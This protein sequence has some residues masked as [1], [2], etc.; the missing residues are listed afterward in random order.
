MDH[1]TDIKDQTL[2]QALKGFVL[3]LFSWLAMKYDVPPEIAVSGAA[4]VAAL[5]AW[6][7]TKIGPDRATASFMGPRSQ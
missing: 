3:G 1:M 2:D 7:S 5:L 6:V 4:L